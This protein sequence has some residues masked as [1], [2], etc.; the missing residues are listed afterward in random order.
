MDAHLHRI[1]SSIMLALA[2]LGTAGAAAAA[3][4]RGEPVIGH[5]IAASGGVSVED[6]EG[7]RRPAVCGDSLHEGD[8]LVTAT[9]AR[10]A[11]LTGDVYAQV[12]AETRVRVGRTETGA[13][14]VTLLQGRARIIDTDASDGRAGARSHRVATPHTEGFGGSDTEVVVSG[15][16]ERAMMCEWGDSIDVRRLDDDTQAVAQSGECAT[17]RP[18]LSVFRAAQDA[19]K[20][21]LPDDEACDIGSVAGNASDLL[22]PVDVAASGGPGFGQQVSPPRGVRPPSLGPCNVGSTCTSA[23][24]PPPPPPALPAVVERP[25]RPALPPGAVPRPPVGLPPGA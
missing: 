10:A 21:A 15:D 8:V 23:G 2:L 6:R 17:A 13:P 25:V 20:L 18:H 11:L 16:R 3:E 24:P 12:G 9:A 19:A 14:D 4:R 22:T 7:V 5:L 1:G